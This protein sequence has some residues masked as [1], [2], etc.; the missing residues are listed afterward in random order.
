[1]AG[2]RREPDG[3]HTL[4]APCGLDALFAM[5]TARSHPDAFTADCVGKQRRL[6]ALWPE[7]TGRGADS[8][9]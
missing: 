8:Y 9:R 1:M 6:Q 3:A 2:L 7:M 4:H 5:E